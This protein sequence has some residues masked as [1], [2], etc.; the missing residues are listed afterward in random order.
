M[1]WGSFM[2]KAGALAVQ[3]GKHLCE[4][5]AEKKE[6]MD[7]Y[8]EETERWDDETLIRRFQS[9]S[10]ERK[11]AYGQALKNRGYGRH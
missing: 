2:K 5:V 10:G 1:D 4:K 11:W 8:I 9:A 6:R 7:G 3:G